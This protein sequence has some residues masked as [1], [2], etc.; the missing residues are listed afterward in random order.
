MR[1]G[2]RRWRDTRPW[3]KPICE[4]ELTAED[5]ESTEIFRK[6]LCVLRALRGAIVFR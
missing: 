5:A 4:S 6:I 3:Y 2:R 1:G